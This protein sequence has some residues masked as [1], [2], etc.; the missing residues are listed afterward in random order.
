MPTRVLNWDTQTVT[1]A[2]AQLGKPFCWGETD[3]V[4]LLRGM[5]QIMY[6]E[7]V[8]PTDPYDDL[9]S[10]CEVH[11]LTGGVWRVLKSFG[12]SELLGVTYASTGDV[13][14]A[15]PREDEPFEAV[16]PVINDKYLFTEPGGL[17][18]LMPLRFAPDDTV[19]YRLPHV[20]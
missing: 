3:C 5:L 9:R 4:S 20:W 16:M 13:L 12:S 19:A 8:G 7:P 11:R 1:W 2:I 6:G 14:L 10:A 17:V 15:S 18:Q